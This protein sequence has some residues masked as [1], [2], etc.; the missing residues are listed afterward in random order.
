MTRP[1][2]DFVLMGTARLWAQRSTCDRNQAGVV[3]SRDGRTLMTG[4]N[5][6]PRGMPHC[7]HATNPEATGCTNA[8]HAEANGISWAARKGVRLEGCEIH[9]TLDPCLGCARLL[10]NLDPTRVTYDHPHFRPTGGVELL[11]T[12]GIEV[13]HYGH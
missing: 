3:F 12:A 1:D 5:G 13:V 11:R 6:A 7:D 2:R 4:Y 8:T 9:C 10:I